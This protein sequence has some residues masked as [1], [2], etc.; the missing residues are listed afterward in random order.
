M[1]DLFNDPLIAH[2]TIDDYGHLVERGTGKFLLSRSLI[3]YDAQT[4]PTEYRE[5]LK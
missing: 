4:L 1:P 5:G 2:M 3:C